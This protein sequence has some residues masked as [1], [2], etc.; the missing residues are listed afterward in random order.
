MNLEDL[1][2]LTRLAVD[3]RNDSGTAWPRG[4]RR[5][6]MVLLGNDNS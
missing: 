6:F 2:Q 1:D 4:Q 5:E 3:L